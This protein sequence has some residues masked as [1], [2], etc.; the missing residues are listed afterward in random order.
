MAVPIHENTV[1]DPGETKVRRPLSVFYGFYYC[2]H[3]RS[4][5][6]QSLKAKNTDLYALNTS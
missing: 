5:G 1:I 2:V 6:V 3:L 4:P